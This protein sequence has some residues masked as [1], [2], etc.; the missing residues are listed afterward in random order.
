MSQT[1]QAFIKA[2]LVAPSIEEER[3]LISNE[4]ANMRTFI[5]DCHDQYKPRII[6]KLLYL[7]MLGH[8]TAWA[9]MDVISLMTH[10]RISYKRIGYLAA[11]TLFDEYNER[12]VLLTATVQRDLQSMTPEVQKMALTLICNICTPEM[13][14]SLVTDVIKLADNLDPLVKKCV[15]MA[16]A[17][18]L[19]KAPETAEQIRPIVAPFLNH[20]SHCV[21]NAGISVA[22]EMLK[23]D[24]SLAEPW[25]QFSVPF[26]KILKTLFETRPAQEFTYGIFNDPF[27]QIKIMQILSSLKSPSDE[28]DDV[29]SSIATGVDVQRNTGRS[30]LLQAVQTIGQAAKKPSLRS[31]AF[32]QVGRLFTFPQPNILYSALSMFS[33]VL[34][35]EHQIIDRSSSDSLVLQRYK[36]QVVHCLDHRDPS[37]RRRALDVVAALVDETNVETLIPEIMSYLK[38]ADGDFRTELVA[39]VFAAIQRFAPSIKW[40]FDT[41]LKIL[42]ESGSY[43]GNDVITSFCK[44]IAQNVD[45][46]SHA[47]HELSIALSSDQDTQPLVQVAAWAIG[48][49]QEEPSD[50]IDVMISLTKMPQT[51]SETKG[52]LITAISKLAIRFNQVE[53]VGNELSS[54]AKNNDLEI[55]Q[56]A[57]EMMRILAKPNISEEILAP[58]EV[59][60]VESEH[61]IGESGET[62]SPIQQADDVNDLLAFDEPAKNETAADLL[63]G[64]TTTQEPPKPK[65]QDIQPPPGAVE[66]MRTSDYVVFFELQKNAMN[67]RQLAIRSTVFNLGEVPLTNFLIQYGVPQGWAIM[68]QPPSSNV[69]EAIGGQPIVQ[70]MMLE[71]RGP[72][73]LMMMTHTSF[74]Y[75]SQPLKETGKINPIFG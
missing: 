11:M 49:F 15:G 71:N 43:V 24:P 38:L 65:P 60:V 4:L 17:S 40:N 27:L 2:I 21:V 68:V 57:G 45:L 69:L 53:L 18:I 35:S 42:R 70:V 7:T 1:T 61:K 62:S 9:Q 19:R 55:Q 75:R 46:R 51:T 41:V 36:S 39:K 56:R 37:I 32:N 72:N 52:Y 14:Q 20:G 10:E 47:I 64:E 67:P 44:L 54:L 22:L 50:T 29:L 16:L 6:N 3:V 63:G 13:G 58:V 48:E 23:I 59:D 30:L 12:I 66:A 33:R 8:E 28:L 5:K 74:M 34:Y 73:P 26:T 25:N 31:L